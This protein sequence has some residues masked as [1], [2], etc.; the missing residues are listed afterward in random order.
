MNIYDFDD[1]IYNGDTNKHIIL[2]GLKK[3]PKLTLNALLKA[4]KL[5]KE[6]KKGMIEFER[7]KE[8]MLSFIFETPNKEEFIKE[9]V[10]THM[11]NIKPWYISKKTENDIIISASY[12]LWIKEFA[13]R[14]GVKYVLG[15]RVDDEGIILGKNCKGEEKIKRLNLLIQDA[16]VA[17]MHSDSSCDIPLFDMAQRGYVVEGNKIK[18]YYKGYKF[19]NNK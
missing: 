19:K 8:V 7:V 14:L 5:N 9:F 15:T 11:K 3:H 13:N 10:D 17:T 6:Y 2:F 1:T 12:E 4:K 18:T 16:K